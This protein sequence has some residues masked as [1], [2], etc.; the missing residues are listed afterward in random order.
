MSLGD[1]HKDNRSTDSAGS[2]EMM[3]SFALASA[4]GHDTKD[5]QRDVKPC[6]VHQTLVHGEAGIAL[7]QRKVE[8]SEEGNSY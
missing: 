3:E 1:T 5:A 6:L 4:D 8:L 2:E 7:A